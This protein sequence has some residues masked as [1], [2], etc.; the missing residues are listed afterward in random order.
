MLS[1]ASAAVAPGDT[2]EDVIAILGKPSGYIGSERFEILYFD[3]GEVVLRDGIVQSH[4]IV[5]QEEAEQKR[6]ALEMERQDYQQRRQ[7]ARERRLAEGRA[8]RDRKTADPEFAAMEPSARLAF[9]QV[10]R[11]KYPEVDIDFEYSVAAQQARLAHSERMAE[12]ERERRLNELERRVAEAEHQARLAEREAQAARERPRYYPVYHHYPR[13]PVIINPP[14]PPMEQPSES[15][16]P[17]GSSLVFRTVTR[18][19]S[20]NPILDERINRPL[21]GITPPLQRLSVN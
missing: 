18:H 16:Q 8:I 12:L 11:Q 14:C 4:T 7:E 10:F 21:P 6:A 2:R 20:G 19:E 13:H 17:R 1:A 9:W 3:R 15:R 5:S